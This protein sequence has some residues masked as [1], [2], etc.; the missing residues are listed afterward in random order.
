MIASRVAP[1]GTLL[2]SGIWEK[3]QVQNVL[4]AY[5]AE[6]LVV[7]GGRAA[8]CCRWRRLGA[9]RGKGAGDSIVTHNFESERRHQGTAATWL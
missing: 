9:Y 5:E 1:G 8:V 4:E 7:D 3:E 2:M 6:G